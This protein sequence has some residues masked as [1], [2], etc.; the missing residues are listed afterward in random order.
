MAWKI[1]WIGLSESFAATLLVTVVFAHAIIFDNFTNI[2]EF[3][4]R[5]MPDLSAWLIMQKDMLGYAWQV[6][7]LGLFIYIPKVV[8]LWT[9]LALLIGAFV[10]LLWQE[11][12][13]TSS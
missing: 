10:Q 5:Y 2:Y 6:G 4:W 13:M 7:Q 3:P 9:G 8:I 1:F 11:Q 12:R